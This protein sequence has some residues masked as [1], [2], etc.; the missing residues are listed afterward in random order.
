MK[1]PQILELRPTQFVLG[2]KEIESKVTK[3]TAFSPK[4]MAA[5]CDS[6]KIPVVIGPK[7]QNYMI[8]HHHFA[9]AC[10]EL[11]VDG[12]SIDVIKDLSDL[13]EKEFW[14]TMTKKDW[15][16]LH[17]QFGMGP[18][19]PLDLP[20]DIRCLADDPFRSLAWVMRDIG[21]VKKV[22]EP[23]FEF[24]WAAFFRLNLDVRVHS[25]SDFKDAILSA[26]KLAGTKCAAHLPG[27]IAAK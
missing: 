16:Y 7:Q 11:K 18:H 13:G 12:Y 19:S 5:F 21:V 2:M 1:K 3:M 15:V 25:K 22:D 9:R 17:D 8:D 27:Y 26:K 14:N 23:F 20:A 6:H 4:E 10:W 24:K